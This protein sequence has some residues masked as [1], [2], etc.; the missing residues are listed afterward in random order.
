MADWDISIDNAG[1]PDPENQGCSPGDQ[2]KW[3]NDSNREIT[4]FNLPSC[5]SPQQSPAPIA[6]GG[7]T[8]WFTVQQGANGTY[9]YSYGWVGPEEG[10]RS[11]T[12]DV[13]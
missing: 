11:G 10:T 7:S 5:V 4:T 1:N 3:T 2:I 8:R 13:S 12:I 9:D 6:A